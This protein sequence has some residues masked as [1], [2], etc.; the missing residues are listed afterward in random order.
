MPNHHAGDLP[1]LLAE[2]SGKAS[3]RT[4][5]DG[6][7]SATAARRTSS[8]G[9]SSSTRIRRLHDAA[10]RQLRRA[11]GLRRHPPLVSAGAFVRS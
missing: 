3:L 7:R 8:A 5:I 1:M 4:E 9:R 6:S 11:R 2:P 10:D